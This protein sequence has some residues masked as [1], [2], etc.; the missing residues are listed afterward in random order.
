MTSDLLAARLAPQLTDLV[1]GI[2][3]R[4]VVGRRGAARLFARVEVLDPA[5]PDEIRGGLVRED[6]AA[7]VTGAWTL[8]CADAFRVFVAEASRADVPISRVELTCSPVGGSRAWA[9]GL[10]QATTEYKVRPERIRI[11]G[12][13]YRAMMTAVRPAWD[14]PG[15]KT[16]TFGARPGADPQLTLLTATDRRRIDPPAELLDLLVEIDALYRSHGRTLT[17]PEWEVE[18]VPGD[19]QLQSSLPYRVVPVSTAR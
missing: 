15:E 2:E 11:D 8:D 3:Q 19:Y 18:G 9:V 10:E 14:V 13:V 1:A 5:H 17:W 16:L 4:L 7:Q 6:G 12:L